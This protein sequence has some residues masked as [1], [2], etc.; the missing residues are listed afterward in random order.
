MN[1]DQSVTV[2][3]I[4]LGSNGKPIADRVIAGGFKVVVTDIR[5]EAG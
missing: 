4:G 2:G 3:F 5:V 1:I